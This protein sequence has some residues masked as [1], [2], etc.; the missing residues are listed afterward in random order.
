MSNNPKFK[1]FNKKGN[2]ITFN[3]KDIDVSILNSIRRVVLSEIPNIAFENE[4]YKIDGKKVDIIQNTCS[5]HNEIILQ[6]L[7]MLPLKFDED[8]I[9]N[10]DPNSS[11]Y[12]FKLL[13]QN[14]TEKMLNVTTEDFEIYD[15]N[16]K[17]YDNKFIRKIFPKN[18]ISG[19][20]ILITKLK[21]NLNDTN[22]GDIFEINADP[23]KK[24]AKD[25]AGFGFVS[26][27]VYYNVVD[28]KVAD[29]ELQKLLTKNVSLSNKEKESLKNDFNNLDRYR[30][31]KKNEYDEPNSFE[32]QIE[33][34]N[35]VSPEFL[36]FKAIVI[37]IKKLEKLIENIIDDKIKVV[38]INNI[39]DDS[40][41][42]KKLFRFEI[43][44]EKHT[45]GNLIQSLFCNFYIREDDKKTIEFVGYN[46]PHPLDNVV[47][48]TIKFNQSI[49]EN[50]INKIFIDG[51]VKIQK[52]LESINNK[53][54]DFSNLNKKIIEVA[55]FL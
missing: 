18:P 52:L 29:E 12:K 15:E 40:N 4:P 33:S 49:N 3:I 2:K 22:N 31:F 28:K 23:S 44:N 41:L 25:Y 26:S 9:F 27:C 43:E 47:H 50:E 54:I 35:R 34:E 55:D 53:W 7:S 10:F 51:I 42:N 24:N 20:F 6:R 21:P 14:K 19:D 11:K 1:N 36:F 46:C 30:H 17:K 39:E 45:I 32:Y 13:K 8:E 5:L 38:K 16:D 48:I 37:I